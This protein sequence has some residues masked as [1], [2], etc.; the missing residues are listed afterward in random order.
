M[1]K[2]KGNSNNVHVQY[3][4]LLGNKIFTWLLSNLF[5]CKGYLLLSITILEMEEMSFRIKSKYSICLAPVYP[6]SPLSHSH[7]T[8][9]LACWALGSIPPYIL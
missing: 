4:V 2:K 1:E 8:A 3:Q 9:Y 6:L 7:L 5:V